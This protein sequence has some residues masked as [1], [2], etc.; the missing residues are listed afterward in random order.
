MCFPPTFRGEG[1]TTVANFGDA[2]SII[3]YDLNPT[4]AGFAYLA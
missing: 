3:G 4:L 2:W 1:N